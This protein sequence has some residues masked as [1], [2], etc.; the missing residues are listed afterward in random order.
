MDWWIWIVIVVAVLAVLVGSA[1]GVQARRRS[2]GVIA[3]RR[4]AIGR[5]AGKGRVK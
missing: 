4:G 1:V 5:R 3:V 2:G